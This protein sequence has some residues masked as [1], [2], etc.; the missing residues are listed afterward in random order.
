MSEIQTSYEIY[1]GLGSNLGDRLDN[2]RTAIKHLGDHYIYPKLFSSLYETSPW[3]YADQPHFLNATISATT[4]LNP[5]EILTKI[6]LIESNMGR[7]KND[8]RWRERLI[9]IDILLIQEHVV[10]SMEL[11]IPHIY[12]HERSF[13]LVP[14]AEISPDIIHPKIGLRIRSL[15]DLRPLLEK[16]SIVKI[17][18]RSWFI[19]N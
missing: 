15:R 7:T 14:L 12:L 3:G 13:V 17:S 5:D 9:D 6:K 11:Q 4:H 19:E 16:Q 2:L 10:E 1:L 18:D 8:I